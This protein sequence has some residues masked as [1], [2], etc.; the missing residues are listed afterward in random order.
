MDHLR[1]SLLLASKLMSSLHSA[2]MGAPHVW[3]TE[4]KA[5][6]RELSKLIVWLEVCL[7]QINEWEK[8]NQARR[9]P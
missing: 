3:A 1:E 7:D 9:R 5:T 8:K 6:M 2:S 4:I